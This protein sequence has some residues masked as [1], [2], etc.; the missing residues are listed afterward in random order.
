M[1]N[2]CDLSEALSQLDKQGGYFIDF[3][4]KTQIQAGI[5]RLHPGD[6]DTQEPHHV[7]EVYYVI[8]GSGLINLNGRDHAVQQG[9]C[10]FVKSGTKHTF[11]GN[12]EDLVVFYALSDCNGAS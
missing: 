12:S 8:R 2:I 10:I 4:T 3:I 5:L 9:S 1:K 11:Y 7:D 6:K